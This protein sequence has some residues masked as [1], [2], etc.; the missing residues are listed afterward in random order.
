[1]IVNDEYD[2][3][4]G[5]LKLTLINEEGDN[6]WSDSQEFRVISLGQHTY[7]FLLKFPELHGKFH[8]TAE[9]VPNDGKES[10][11][12]LRKVDILNDR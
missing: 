11:R 3:Q 7:E 1:M 4:A 12:S 6:V 10:T 9:A 2:D 8:L 5:Q